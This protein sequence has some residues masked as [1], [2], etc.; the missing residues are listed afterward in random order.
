[1]TDYV[2]LPDCM[3]TSIHENLYACRSPAQDQPK[4][5]P[6][7]YSLNHQQKHF[8]TAPSDGEVDLLVEGCSADPSVELRNLCRMQHNFC[9]L[10]VPHQS[11]SSPGIRVITLIPVDTNFGKPLEIRKRRAGTVMAYKVFLPAIRGCV[12]QEPPSTMLCF[13]SKKS[14]AYC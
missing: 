6:S 11:S 9:I 5:L 12:A 2:V 4:A 10:Q 7:N 13:P 8:Y 14:A 3:N 1:M